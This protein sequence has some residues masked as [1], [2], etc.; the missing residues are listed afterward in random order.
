MSNKTIPKPTSKE[1]LFSIGE[2]FYALESLIIE[3]EGEITDEIDQWLDEYQAKEADKIDAY[4]YIIQKFDDIAQEAQRLATRSTSYKKKVSQLKDRLKYYLERRARDK[5]QTQRFIV[6]I[7]SNGGQLPMKLNEDVKPETLPD[8]FTR[9]YVEP[10]MQSI[11]QSI[12]DGD[13]EA[14]KIAQIL[15]RGTHVRIK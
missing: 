12:L 7:C 8:Q 9:K 3:Q 2:H 1:S 10:D 4:C 6:S 11:R 13:T 15:P 14:M 5:I